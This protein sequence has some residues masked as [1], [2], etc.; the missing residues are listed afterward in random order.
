[1]EMVDGQ[2]KDRQETTARSL[3]KILTMISAAGEATPT[4]GRR[5]FVRG[6]GKSNMTGWH[7][8]PLHHGAYMK[9]SKAPTPCQQASTPYESAGKTALKCQEQKYGAS[10]FLTQQGVRTT[11]SKSVGSLRYPTKSISTFGASI[12][13]VEVVLSMLSLPRRYHHEDRAGT[14]RVHRQPHCR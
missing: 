10:R 5:P 9:S 4:F 3:K 1:M 14:P 12:F 7:V 13:P 2:Q 11:P 8:R 6:V